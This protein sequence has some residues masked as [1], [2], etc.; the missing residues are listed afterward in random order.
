MDFF[1]SYSE[2]DRDFEELVSRALARHGTV[3]ERATVES[4]GLDLIRRW[5]AERH[6]RPSAVISLI[7]SSYMAS[8]SEIANAVLRTDS[9]VW[10]NVYLENVE[11]PPAALLRP[12]IPL[13]GL[14][15]E[16]AMLNLEIYFD[17]LLGDPDLFAPMPESGSM[18]L[19]SRGPEPLSLGELLE[20]RKQAGADNNTLVSALEGADFSMNDPRPSPMPPPVPVPQAQASPPS[21][22]PL[23]SKRV[24]G[25]RG[26]V[27]W[28]LIGGAVLLAGF[29]L[30]DWLGHLL[31]GAGVMSQ[32]MVQPVPPQTGRVDVSAF[33][34]EGGAPGEKVLVQVLLH[35][36]ADLRRAGRQARLADPGIG[37]RMTATLTRDIAAGQLVTVMVEGDEVAVDEPVQTIV[38]RG[39]PVAAQFL[40]MLSSHLGQVYLRCRLLVDSVPVGSLRFALRVSRG[41][42]EQRVEMRGDLKRRYTRAFLSYASAD[43]AEVLKRVQGLRAAG[44]DFFQDVLSLEPGEAWEQRLYDEIDR[45]DLFL[46]FWSSSAAKSEWVTREIERAVARQFATEGSPEITPVIIEG[47][48]VASPIPNSLRHLHFNDFVVLAALSE[49][50]PHT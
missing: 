28:L 21:S 41:A 12:G 10:I 23:R 46:L 6:G 34:P 43:R 15:R 2:R 48:P 32:G 19:T 40:V 16:R 9:L 14:D 26:W 4:G 44:I 17:A 20:R 18:G 45:C 24:A 22:P 50:R 33:A 31:A 3:T 5:A 7:S 25:G 38:W 8:G 37:R 39:E 1:V 30:K 11:R 49:T 42:V 29:A 36:E 47:P 13:E 27:D 35:S